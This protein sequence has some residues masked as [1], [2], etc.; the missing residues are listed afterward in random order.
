[1]C[2]GDEYNAALDLTIP[3]TDD[4]SGVL[5]LDISKFTSGGGING[6]IVNYAIQWPRPVPVCAKY[7]MKADCTRWT[8]YRLSQTPLSLSHDSIL[9]PQIIWPKITNSPIDGATCI[10]STLD[11]GAAVMI[12]PR[13]MM[14]VWNEKDCSHASGIYDGNYY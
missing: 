1:M 3:S 8:S 10:N 5:C 2:S 11:A 6:G 9:H 4:P 12:A 14:F 13:G 7:W